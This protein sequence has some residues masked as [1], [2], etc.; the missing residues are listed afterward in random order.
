MSE[1]EARPWAKVITRGFWKIHPLLKSNQ[2]W[3]GEWESKVEQEKKED[4]W[5]RRVYC[6]HHS[7]ALLDV[8]LA[9]TVQKNGAQPGL[10]PLLPWLPTTQPARSLPASL[11]PIF[12]HL[13]WWGQVF[14]GGLTSLLSIQF[15]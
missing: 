8:L 10:A 2:E 11:D 15:Y 13:L 6:V 7:T 3:K 14:S 5:A 12:C 9:C 4:Y 1:I